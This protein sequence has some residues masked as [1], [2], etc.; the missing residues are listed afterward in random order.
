MKDELIRRTQNDPNLS[1]IEKQARVL[2]YESC[3]LDGR[4]YELGLQM[5]RNG[6]QVL[7]VDK[8]TLDAGDGTGTAPALLR[9][10]MDQ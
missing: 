6:Q 5:K 7:V 2:E 3:F 1:E 8:I 4:I 10:R 9:K